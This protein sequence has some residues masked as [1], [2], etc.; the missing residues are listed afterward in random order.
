MFRLVLFFFFFPACL[1]YKTVSGKEYETE[2]L[3]FALCDLVTSI[4]WYSCAKFVSLWKIQ[5]N[6]PCVR[7]A[8]CGLHSGLTSALAVRARIWLELIN[9]KY[10]CV[11]H[12]NISVMSLDC[13]LQ[14]SSPRRWN[15][16]LL[17]SDTDGSKPLLLNMP[18][19]AHDQQRTT[20]Y[21]IHLNENEDYVEYLLS[22]DRAI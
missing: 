3:A 21:C 6:F 4:V 17:S 9:F 12:W 13:F 18:V 2:K 7:W 10:L 11:D 1:L 19:M 15:D 5:T 16:L 14:N 22:E 20:W 8:I